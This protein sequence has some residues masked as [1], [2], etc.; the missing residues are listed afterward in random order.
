MSRELSSSFS[1]EV[2]RIQVKAYA[3]LWNDS[4][5]ECSATF[6]WSA[7]NPHALIFMPLFRNQVETWVF[8]TDLLERGSKSSE[9]VGEGQVIVHQTINAVRVKMTAPDGEHWMRVTVMLPDV[10]RFLGA[11]S[12]RMLNLAEPEH[13]LDAE[14]AA[15]LDDRGGASGSW[16]DPS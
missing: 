10:V 8:A 4:G 14:L 7:E 5:G 6:I 15:M 1:E 9:P 11:V 13:D 16:E 2:V 3:R 12:A